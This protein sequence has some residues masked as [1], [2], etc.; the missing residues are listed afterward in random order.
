MKKTIA[1][2]LT[3]VTLCLCVSLA[4]CKHN[5]EDKDIVGVTLESQTINYD[6]EKHS[7]QVKGNLPQ[8]ANVEYGYTLVNTETV[9]TDGV[10]DVGTYV[11]NA[12]VT[13][14]GYKTL[15]LNATL[16]IKGEKFSDDIN[17]PNSSYEW[18]QE[19]QRKLA[20]YGA[21]P[22]GTT[23]TYYY[24][25]VEAD[26]VTDVGIHEV[27]AVLTK[28][29]YETKTI[30]RTLTIVALKFEHSNELDLVDQTVTYDGE[31]HKLEPNMDVYE[32]LPGNTNINVTYNGE[33]TVEGVSEVG[34]Y[35]VKWVITHEGYET[36]TLEGTLTITSLQ[37]EPDESGELE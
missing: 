18:V 20:V 21:I 4:A 12:T 10:I 19:A 2:I 9:F 32:F 15:E 24:D 17:M 26:Y 8:G 7:L 13:C 14:T 36:V 1:I 11:V 29:G 22:E 6:G 25:G 16:T 35:K 5:N 31:L 27:K 37:V 23:I 33:Q 30:T 28:P 34:V 3:L